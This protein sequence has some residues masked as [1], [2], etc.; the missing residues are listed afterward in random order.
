M[1]LPETSL[2]ESQDNKEKPTFVEAAAT[3]FR[4]ALRGVATR[5]LEKVDSFT[6]G[7]KRQQATAAR[8]KFLGEFKQIGLEA[9][10][11]Y[12]DSFG[13]V[14]NIRPEQVYKP[15]EL[16]GNEI[17][18]RNG[19]C[20]VLYGEIHYAMSTLHSE[21]QL[22]M[23]LSEQGIKVDRVF[24][25]E[26]ESFQADVDRYLSTGVLTESLQN[27]MLK[28]FV[29]EDN[30]FEHFHKLNILTVCRELGI[31]VTF[32]DKNDHPDRDKDWFEKMQRVLGD[33][34]QGTNVLF[35]GMNH[36]N[37][38][39]FADETK[40]PPVAKRLA[41]KYGS[42]KVISIMNVEYVTDG[43]SPSLEKIKPISGTLYQEGLARLGLVGD[44]CASSLGD[45][46]IGDLPTDCIPGY[47]RES[48]KS[49]DII[50]SL[51]GTYD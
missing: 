27:Y 37:K 36:C 48:K 3:Q 40:A 45:L 24:M 32:L 22:L 15:A 13:E 33:K 9:A 35:A 26:D 50:T 14:G 20:L 39:L 51:P 19:N 5:V 16:I 2:S 10:R 18:K 38:D 28:G 29:R 11:A 44:T 49:F 34:V 31:P 4:L 47:A 43:S 8:V 12:L 6:N 42:A 7:D 46:N 25:E 30:Y 21:S 41:G 17:L 23:D 1:N